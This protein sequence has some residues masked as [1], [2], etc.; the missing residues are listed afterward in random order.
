MLEFGGLEV[1]FIEEY[2][3]ENLNDKNHIKKICNLSS[4]FD[5]FNFDMLKALVE[6]MNRYN[7]TPQEVLRMLNVKV[8]EANNTKFNVQLFIDGEEI[9]NNKKYEVDKSWSGNPLSMSV[10]IDWG[11]QPS[12]DFEETECFLPSDLK[13]LDSYSGKYTFINHKGNKVIITKEKPSAFDY[14]TIL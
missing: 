14:Y 3:E 7:E 9:S 13:T 11:K 1:P 4:M 2:C 5:K 10:C 8:S 6:E 12:C